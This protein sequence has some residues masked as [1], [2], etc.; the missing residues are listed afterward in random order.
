MN[1]FWDISGSELEPK[2]PYVRNGTGFNFDFSGII[3]MMGEQSGTIHINLPAATADAIISASGTPSSVV[4]DTDWQQ[5]F[6]NILH[7]I[8]RQAF[9]DITY[10]ATF[11]TP[12]ILK[13]PQHISDN[14]DTYLSL[15]VPFNSIFGEFDLTFC[16][17]KTESGMNKSTYVSR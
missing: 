10:D 6:E 1:T 11:L 5:N 17:Q 9:E 4:S 8:W 15:V 3:K 14:S 7:R 16:L 12:R 2:K 13:K